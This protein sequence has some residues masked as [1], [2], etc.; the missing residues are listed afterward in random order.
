MSKQGTAELPVAIVGAGFSG[1][2]LAVNLLRLG[3]R[4][5]LI[6]RDEAFLAKGVAYGTRRAEHLLNVRVSNMSA[7]PDDADHFL[8]WMG[9]D[10]AEQANRFVHRLTYG[11]YVHEQFVAA[12]AAAPDRLRVIGKEALALRDEGDAVAVALAGGETVRARAA[13]LALG[14]FPPPPFPPFAGLPES[15]YFANPWHPGATE[16]L[17]T[18]EHILLL[19]TGLTAIDMVLSLE[20]AGYRGK[21]TALS[22]RG[23]SPRAHADRGPV[24]GAVACPEARGSRLVR[25]VRDRVR[26]VGWRAAIDE[27]RPHTQSLWRRHDEAAQRRFLRHLRP[28]WDVHRHRLAPRVAER[29]AA[30]EAEGRLEFLAG[31]VNG[32]HEAKEPVQVVWRPRGAPEEQSLTVGR[33]IN[34]TGPAGDVTRATLPL[35]RDLLAAGRIRPDVH[36]LGL[37]VDHSG[38]VKN[39]GGRPQDRLFA[40]GPITKGEAWEIIA[41][42][43]IRRQVWNLARLLTSSHWVG[44]EGL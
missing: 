15:L 30:L 9:F 35:L 27:L 24:V 42:P 36:R 3:A 8:R 28:W 41:V 25:H 16:N 2:L 10:T 26:Y 14:N 12:L 29:I 7:Y 13:V 40:V 38:R 17:D 34:C 18:V 32:A 21:I 37:D 44:G 4:V 20:T 33:I 39:A 23:L 6:E 31:K 22:R 43:D 5:V 19:G 1:T 11:H